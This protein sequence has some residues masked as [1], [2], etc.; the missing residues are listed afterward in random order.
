MT[1]IKGHDTF[2]LLMRRRALTL[3]FMVKCRDGSDDKLSSGALLRLLS[4]YTCCD[5]D[6]LVDEPGS[7]LER[8]TLGGYHDT[9]RIF[10]MEKLLSVEKQV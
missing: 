9:K 2:R 5:V 7:C 6:R 10:V 8:M 3:T 1:L 4:T